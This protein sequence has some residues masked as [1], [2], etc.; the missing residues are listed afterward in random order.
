M[1]R[2]A[3]MAFAALCLPACEQVRVRGQSYPDGTPRWRE[4]FAVRNGNAVPDGT[5]ESLDLF[6]QGRRQGY[7][8]RWHPN[9][10]LRSAEHFT[11]GEPD[12]RARYW[13]EEGSPIACYDAGS[14]GCPRTASVREDGPEPRVARP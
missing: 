1:K 5:P 11:D 10:R 12:G 8:L 9:G 3:M 6:A 7:S 14:D 4:T 2:I 13:D